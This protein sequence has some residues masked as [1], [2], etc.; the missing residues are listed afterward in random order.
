MQTVNVDLGDR[1]YPIFIG[2]DLLKDDS[3]LAPYLGKG[4]VIVVTNEVVAPLYLETVKDL[5]GKQFSSVIILS[6]IHI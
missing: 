4:R 2:A 6:L 5:L 1:S 3:I